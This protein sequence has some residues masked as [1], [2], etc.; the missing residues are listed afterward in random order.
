MEDS[1]DIPLKNQEWNH[2]MTQQSHY[3]AYTL[4]KPKLKK[5]HIPQCSLQR[6]KLSKGIILMNLWS[7]LQSITVPYIYNINTSV[8]TC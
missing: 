4:R 5:T 1:M 3:Y 2:C 7:C 6:P 8:I